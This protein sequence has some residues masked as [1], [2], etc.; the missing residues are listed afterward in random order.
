MRPKGLGFYIFPMPSGG[1]PNKVN[2]ALLKGSLSFPFTQTKVL[3]EV[4]TPK[5]KKKAGFVDIV[6]NH[7]PASILQLSLSPSPVTY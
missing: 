7:R 5:G 6:K 4:Q 3:I 2:K 1:N